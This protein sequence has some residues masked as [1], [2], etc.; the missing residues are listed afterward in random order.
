M[1]IVDESV[2][3]MFGYKCEYVEYLVD[4]MIEVE[5]KKEDFDRG[6]EKQNNREY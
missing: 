6:N 5:D 2:N 3:M 4:L 1:T